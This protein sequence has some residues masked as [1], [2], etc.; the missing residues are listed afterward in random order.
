MEFPAVLGVFLTP[1]ATMTRGQ[2][3]LLLSS[4]LGL[5]FG[6]RKGATKKVCDKDFAKR[7]GELSG[8]IRFAS[9]PLFY[10][11]SVDNDR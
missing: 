7:S 9:K 11:V 6:D 2:S 8:A 10:W 4:D 1:A 3:T 5:N